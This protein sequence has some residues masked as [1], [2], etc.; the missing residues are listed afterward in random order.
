MSGD[1]V[2]R[3]YDSPARAQAALET[4]RRIRAAAAELFVASGYAATSMKAIAAAAGV[5][6]RTVFLVFPTK[7]ALL[8]ECIRVAV[9]GDDEATPLLARD[10]FRTALEAPPNRMLGRLADASTALMGRAA[11]LLAVG[12]AVGPDDPV[13]GAVRAR[14]H[15]ATRA[16]ML[17]VARALERAGALREG[18]SA[19]P[20]ADAMY[21]LAASES[22]YLRLVDQRGWSPEAYAR[23]L[24][25]ALAGALLRDAD[26]G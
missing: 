6:E 26:G 4:R 9:R 5:S 21:A 23:T 8:G 12:E 14:G 19:E 20:A 25:R 7:A 17:E 11:R 24:E 18:M 22:V 3:R 2:K 1:T 15:A 16:D 13:L 10:D